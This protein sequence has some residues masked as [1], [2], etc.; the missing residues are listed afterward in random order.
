MPNLATVYSRELYSDPD[1]NDFPVTTTRPFPTAPGGLPSTSSN[2]V[3]SSAASDA[4]VIKPAPVLG[5]EANQFAGF[6]WSYSDTPTGGQILI[7][8]GSTTILDM[9]I[10]AAGP[11]FIPFASAWTITPNSA[12]TITIKSGGG[13]VVGTVG[14]LQARV[15]PVDPSSGNLGGSALLIPGL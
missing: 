9:R 11:G 2:M 12:L 5:Y 14:F 10:T 6:W 1:G 15:V 4:S 8:D 3:V 13:S 7:L